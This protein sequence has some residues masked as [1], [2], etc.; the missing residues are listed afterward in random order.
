MTDK[1]ARSTPEWSGKTPDTPAPTQV[2]VRVFDR[3]DGICQCGCERVILT[4]DKWQ[5]DHT[6]AVINGGENRESNLRTLLLACHKAKTKQDVAE[7]ARVYRKRAA[8]LGVKRRRKTGPSVGE[9]LQAAYEK[10]LA[11]KGSG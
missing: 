8:H 7:K 10:V 3:D 6:V 2:R 4:G 5:T 9:R 11:R 1:T